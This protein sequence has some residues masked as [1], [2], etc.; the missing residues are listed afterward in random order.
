MN[1]ID[2]Q[3]VY[4]YTSRFIILFNCKPFKYAVQNNILTF[5]ES[6]SFITNPGT[7]ESK[8]IITVYGTGDITLTINEEIIE[9]KDVHSKMILNTELQ[10]AY[11]ENQESL[12][13]KMI[14]EFIKLQ[15]GINKVQWTGNVVKIEILPN[16]RWL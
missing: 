12:N 2:F 15:P 9:L 13:T 11:D 7:I 3:Q 8:P 6:E 1:S 16:W 4:K 14:G 10:D 5:T